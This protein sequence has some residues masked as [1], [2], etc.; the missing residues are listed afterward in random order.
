MNES[1]SILK[2]SK[3][4]S[5]VSYNTSPFL[6]IWRNVSGRHFHEAMMIMKET[7]QMI[8]WN[9]RCSFHYFSIDAIEEPWILKYF[10]IVSLIWLCSCKIPGNNSNCTE[11]HLFMDRHRWFFCEFER[12]F[13]VYEY[14]I[15]SDIILCM[16][17]EHLKYIHSCL[18]IPLE[19]PLNF[20]FGTHLYQ[21][22]VTEVEW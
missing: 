2:S 9:G 12:S 3:V 19:C 4:L 13:S 8:S 21:C 10:L 17:T 7:V 1:F 22:I 15:L 6:M 16:A 18:C 11:I 20:E 14:I 5:W